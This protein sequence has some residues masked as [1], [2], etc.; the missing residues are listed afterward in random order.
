MPTI[1]QLAPATATSDTDE[2]IV[3]QTGITRRATLAQAISGLQPQLALASGTLL[4]RNSTGIG[5]PEAVAVGANLVL[6]GGTLAATA[7]SYAVAQLAAGT[8]P[9]AADLVP[10][11]QGGT[12]TAVSYATFMAGLSGLGSINASSFLVQ[13]T[14]S[15]TSETLGTFAAGTLPLSG[16]S[17]TGPLALSADPTTALGAATKQYVDGQAAAALP[18]SG[19]ALTGPLTLPA[20][21]TAPLQAATKQYVDSQVGGPAA[22]PLSGGTLTGALTLA[23]NPTAGLQ[24]TPK[25]Y[26]DTAVAT[27]LP[28]SGGALTG[29]LA[30]PGVPAAALDAA[31]K[32]YVDSQVAT[33]LPLAGGTLTGALMLAGNPA[34]ALGATPRQYVDAVAA[35][36]LPLV[37]GALTGP[38]SLPANPTAPLQAATKQYVDS[39]VGGPAALPLSGGT[40]T[41]A[42][43]L[44]GNPTSGLQAAPKQYVDGA[45]ATAL[46]LTGGTLTGPLALPGVPTGALDAAPKTYVDS[47]VATSLPLAGGTLTGAL[48][49][50]GNPTTALGAAPRQYVDA[51][52]AA[53]MPIAGGAMTGP[54]NLAA[55][56]T[57]PLQAAPKQYVDSQVATAL[58]LAGGTLSG[59]L[60]LAGTPTSAQGAAPKSYVDALAASVLPLSGGTLTGPLALA[61]DPATAQQ[62]ATKHYVDTQASAALPITGGT[63]SGPLTVPGFTASGTIA[64]NGTV[65]AGTVGI[66]QTGSQTTTLPAAISLSRPSTGPSDAPAFSSTI[67]VD[68]SGGAPLSYSNIALTTTINDATDSSGNFIDGTTSDVYAFV[69]NL[70]V[71]AVTGS[72][73]SST[74]S[75]HV[76]LTGAATKKTPTGGYPVG[77]TGAQMWG[78]WLP[79]TDATNET[80]SVA[81]AT[82]GIEMDTDCNGIDPGNIRKAFQFV[83]GEAVPFASG[84]YPAEWAYGIYFTTTATGFYKWQISAGGN[85]SVAVIDTRNA[86]PG[87]GKITASLTAPAA[88]IAVDTILPF[89]SA[90][91]Y[92]N[93][94]SA[95]NAA[96]IRVG[97]NTYTHVGFSVDGGGKTSGTLTFSTPVSV[98][99]GAAGTAVIGDS[100]TIWMATGQQIAFDYGGT[101]NLFYDT[102]VGGTHLTSALTTDGEITAM[103]GLAISG[104]ALALPNYTVATLPSSP[105]GSIAYASNGR[106]PWE[107]AG[108]GTGVLVW[109]STN[110]WLSI[111]S[112]TQVQA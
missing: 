75:Q 63:L 109:V 14:G 100:R 49:L 86:F 80:S 12:N 22:L 34:A 57:A 72:N 68:H 35:A 53:S 64:L 15:A 111:L 74:G 71:N 66:T 99:D 43:T 92:G 38:L 76:A 32:G 69:S 36:S 50:P 1:D 5:G 78:L 83:M 90:G 105:N 54:L 103:G 2:L 41:G 58:P 65:T 28:L 11:G 85:Y 47:E 60:V 20:N 51:V 9:A 44:A 24:A 97:A 77:R 107:A 82:T 55:S 96:S 37:G 21:P 81:G 88:T 106:K 30:L 46:P 48:T 39:L 104:G 31:P 19:G 6:S 112:G 87:R 79:V 67:T 89:T 102:A 70:N 29:P 17:M 40:L 33:A 94:V 10:L 42:L 25:Q 110:R 45:I 101:A 16:G 62:A 61:A 108:A 56:P 3:N 98:A 52:A 13:P 26:V 73:A 18:K 8:V 84:G 91:V 95:T 7:T 4:G 23:G 27:A 59:Q 93:P